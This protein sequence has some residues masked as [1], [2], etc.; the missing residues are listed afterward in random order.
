MVALSSTY[1]QEYCGTTVYNS[2][3]IVFLEVY[4]SNMYMNFSSTGIF[5]STMTDILFVLYVRS[6]CI[7]CF[8]ERY[9]KEYHGK[10][11]PKTTKNTWHYIRHCLPCYMSKNMVLPLYHVQKH[12]NTMVLWYAMVLINY[13]VY[14]FHIPWYFHI[15]NLLQRC[16]MVLP[17][18]IPKN[19]LLP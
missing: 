7:W 18:Y 11:K 5:Q 19:M 1:V 8:K 17:W 3:S 6:K 15:L 2:S 10:A 12:D 14:Q 16:S 13:I 4:W 9:L